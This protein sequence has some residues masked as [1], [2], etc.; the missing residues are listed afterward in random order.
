MLRVER[1]AVD[2]VRTAASADDLVG[3]VQEAVRLEFSTI[4]PYLTAMLSLKPGQNREIWWAIHD[5]VVDEMLHLLIGCNLLNALR[6]RPAIDDPAFIPAYPGPLPLGIGSGLV[7]GLEAFSLDVV[8]NVFMDI[9]EPE[10]PLSFPGAAA[11]ADQPDFS[12]IGEF[13]RTLSTKLVEL[14]DSALSGDPARQVVAPRWF[15]AERLFAITNVASAVRALALVV[16]EGEGTPDAPIDPDGDVAH[17]YRFEAI[18]R[19]RR[20]VRDDTVPAGYSF[21]GPPYSFDPAG[22]WPLTANQRQ[23]DL[24][25][26]SEAWRRVQQFRVTFTRLLGSLQRVIDGEPDH[27]DTAMGVMFELKLAGQVLA[28]LPAI[29]GGVPSGRHAGPVFEY[30]RMNE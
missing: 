5:V 17:Y 4:P 7:V 13:Y 16:A 12:T 25:R 22:V 26:C 21:S 28:G 20:L 30:A 10:R 24:D 11:A 23:A 18:W 2:A 27:L 6:A 15:A 19:G 8:K 9:E 1:A 3:L 14:G 29:S